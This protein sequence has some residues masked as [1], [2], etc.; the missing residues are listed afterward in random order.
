MEDVKK[1]ADPSKY[2]TL[3]SRAADTSPP[4]GGA[5]GNSFFRRTD[6]VHEYLEI[7]TLLCSTKLTQN[8]QAQSML[9]FAS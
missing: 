4:A 9:S 6:K 7:S 5:Q 2:I 8:G 1:L 3:P